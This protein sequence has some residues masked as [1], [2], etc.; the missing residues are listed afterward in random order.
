MEN[1]V[2]IRGVGN[3]NLDG[4]ENVSWVVLAWAFKGVGVGELTL[5]YDHG[6]GKWKAK[7]ET[8]TREFV[9]RVLLKIGESYEVVD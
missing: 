4:E 7:T 8:M 9:Q 1:E 2:W 3:S 5:L 6:K